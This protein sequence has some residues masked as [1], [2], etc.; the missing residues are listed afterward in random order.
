MSTKVYKILFFLSLVGMLIFILVFWLT[1]KIP[2][3]LEVDFLDVGQGDAI[4]IKSPSDHNILI[5]GGP[6]SSV[7]DELDENLKWWDRTIDLM[8]LT[9][10][11]DDHVTGLI[12]VV[13]R[14]KV[15]KIIYTGIN[16]TGPNCLEWLKVV[17]EKNVPVVIID[18][19]QKIV[20]NKNVY[21]DILYPCE[22]FLG[23]NVE[24][25]NNTSIV[26]KLVHKSNSFLFMGD[27]EREVEEF[28]VKEGYNLRGKVLKVGHHGSDTSS[29]KDFLKKVNPE[30][31][32]IQVGSDNHFGHPDIRVLKR[33]ERLGA[34]I[35]RNNKDGTVRLFSDGYN[36]IYDNIILH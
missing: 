22:S 19:K 7:I 26:A 14:Y 30:F 5:D 12:D 33:L 31:V 9:H 10:P 2:K 4:L 21:I 15:K 28:L 35:F 8:I 34:K 13:K 16:H 36:I 3:N 27:A 23:K 29:T 25:L 11:H 32:I 1:F 20:L 6:D 17:K 24:N 18:H